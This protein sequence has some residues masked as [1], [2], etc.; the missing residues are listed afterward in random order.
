MGLHRG[1]ALRTRRCRAGVLLGPLTSLPVML[2]AVVFQQASDIPPRRVF[3]VWVG[4]ERADGKKRPSKCQ[5]GAPLAPQHVD[6][7][8]AILVDVAM[9]DLRRELHLRRLEGV[10]W[11]DCE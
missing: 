2:F 4:K 1:K 7:D 6:A 3:R 8:V 5:C 9:E 10:F 11:R